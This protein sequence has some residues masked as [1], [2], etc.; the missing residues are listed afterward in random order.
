MG[1]MTEL[2]FLQ[3]CV[4]QEPGSAELLEVISIAKDEKHCGIAQRLYANRS[5]AGDVEI[6]RVYAREYDPKYHQ[7]SE[8]FPAPDAAT[9][10]YWYET[11]LSQAP[12]DTEA[13]QRFEE[14]RP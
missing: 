13:K 2:A 7:P 12:D 14:L 3:A 1:S 4:K 9:A 10:A 5:Q 11:I 8:C 6:A